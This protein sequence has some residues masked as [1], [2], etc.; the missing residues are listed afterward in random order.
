MFRQEHPRLEPVQPAKIV[1]RDIINF[2]GQLALKGS[3]VSL[4]AFNLEGT[5]IEINVNQAGF[6]LALQSTSDAC[7]LEAQKTGRFITN[8][9]YAI[10]NCAGEDNGEYNVFY[11]MKAASPAPQNHFITR[12]V[13][14]GWYEKFF[15][16][17]DM[18]D[19]RLSFIDDLYR[20]VMVKE[21]ELVTN[22][23]GMLNIFKPDYPETHEVEILVP[24]K[25]PG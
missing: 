14:A 8:R 19:I 2:Q 13:P 7:Y 22:G 25:F 20:W 4:D 23:I 9:Y 1:E 6:E 24:I 18:F 21:I 5:Q 17:G 16:T 11:G 15:Y 3:G 12:N 10:V